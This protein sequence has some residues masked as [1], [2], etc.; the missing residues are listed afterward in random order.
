M[1][2]SFGPGAP[3]RAETLDPN[4]DGTTVTCITPNKKGPIVEGC[5][6]AA[7]GG[8]PGGDI[9]PEP[10]E[11]DGNS[12]ATTGFRPQHPASQGGRDARPDAQFPIAKA[13]VRP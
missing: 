11:K 13:L 4:V 10:L 5:A 6:S 2:A 12:E 9:A 3:E 8:T 1:S 7:G